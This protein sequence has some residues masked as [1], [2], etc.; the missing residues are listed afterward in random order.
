MD[1]ALALGQ[2]AEL[3][4][5]TMTERE[6]RRWHTY[7]LKRALPTRRLEFYLAQIAQMIAITMGG[8]KEAK[9]TDYLIELESDDQP[10]PLNDEDVVASARRAF[11]FNPRK[12]D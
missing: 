10:P 11:G 9:I 3:L 8:A 1:M 4:A 6:L 7:A 2:P 12:G 5:R